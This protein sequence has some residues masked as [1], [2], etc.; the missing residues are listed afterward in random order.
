MTK[1]QASLTP[2]CAH[3]MNQKKHPIAKLRKLALAQQ[4]LLKHNSFGKGLVGVE[5]AIKHIGYV[6]IDT[7]S[8]VER[9][10]HHTIWSRVDNYKPQHLPQLLERKKIFEYWFHA[11]AILP[12][13]DFRFALPRMESFKAGE[14]HWFKN[15]DKKLMRN[16]LKR[17]EIEGPLLAR[18]F[19][20]TKNTN[21][22]WWDWKPAKQALEQLFMQGELMVASREG[23]QKRYDLTERVLPN[24]I[25]T[26]IPSIENEAQH[27]VDTTIRA[28]V[29]CT[30]TNRITFGR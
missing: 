5:N 12:I 18:D 3:K 2:I 24:S 11:A 6:Q 13:D 20:D 29:Q 27:L 30:T 25:D 22:G 17:I 21:T 9:A 8:V 15:I 23:F 19:E 28:R 16:V 4:G 10:H 7:I 26:R 14:K 1:E